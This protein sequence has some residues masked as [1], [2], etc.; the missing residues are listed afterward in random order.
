MRRVFLEGESCG[1]TFSRLGILKSPFMQLINFA[2][3]T[4]SFSSK[5]WPKQISTYVKK[6]SECMFPLSF[7]AHHWLLSQSSIVDPMDP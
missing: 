3:L 5:P 7:A 1:P 2:R 6:P 4:Y